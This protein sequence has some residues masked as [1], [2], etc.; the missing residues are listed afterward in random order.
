MQ[1]SRAAF[2]TPAA[3]PEAAFWQI[4]FRSFFALSDSWLFASI[5]CWHEAT[6]CWTAGEL[7]VVA[8][9][10]A[11]FAWVFVLVVFF[12]VFLPPPPQPATSNPLRSRAT[13]AT[14]NGLGIYP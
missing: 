5:V 6:A 11:G 10:E 12:A 3:S 4:P 2:R 14:C 7:E 8:G 13:R 1:T 9:V